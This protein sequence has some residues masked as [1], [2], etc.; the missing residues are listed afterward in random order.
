MQNSSLLCSEEQMRFIQKIT[1]ATRQE[2]LQTIRISRI[3]VEEIIGYLKKSAI[4][5]MQLAR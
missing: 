4:N 2:V 1:N 3:S 5:K